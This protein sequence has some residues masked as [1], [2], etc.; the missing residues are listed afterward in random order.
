MR[1]A[2]IDAFREWAS[3]TVGSNLRAGMRSEKTTGRLNMP[4]LTPPMGPLPLKDSLGMSVPIAVKVRQF[5]PMG[6]F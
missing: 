5:C 1:R 3:S 2:N 6:N 4:S